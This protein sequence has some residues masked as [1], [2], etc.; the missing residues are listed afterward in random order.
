M[1]FTVPPVPQGFSLKGSVAQQSVCIWSYRDL[2][3]TSDS[4][5][6]QEQ[7]ISYFCLCDRSL[8]VCSDQTEVFLAVC[9]HM[10]SHGEELILAEDK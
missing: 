7:I 9:L 5:C 2:C 6:D 4:L 10:F 8:S 3:F 1:H